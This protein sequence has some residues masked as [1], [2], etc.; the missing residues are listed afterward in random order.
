MTE[1]G[2]GRVLVASLHQAIAD[3]LPGR[4]EFYENWLNP[5]GLRN[6]T[7]GLAPLHAVLS[8]LRQD[9][10][11]YPRV[12]ELAGRYAAEWT[13][14]AQGG[15]RQWL[16]RFSPRPFRQRAAI[17]LIRRTVRQ[18]YAGSRAVVR[19]R[20]GRGTVD[21]RAS[22]FCNVREA[23]PAPLCGFYAALVSRLLELHR[24]DGRVEVRA[25]RAVGD[26]TCVLD[27]HPGV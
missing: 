17:A 18:S 14:A 24:V 10:H 13:M 6:G 22:L 2:I 7:I 1:A 23:A 12:V 3:L 27:V 19:L 16:V 8:F 9:D 15:R 11:V 26:R 25:C 5:T 20:R 21:L 4:L